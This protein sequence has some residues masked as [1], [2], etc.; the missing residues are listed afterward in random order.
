M[1]LFVLLGCKLLAGMIRLQ[2]C[3]KWSSLLFV[4]EVP[5]NSACDSKNEDGTSTDRNW[6]EEVNNLF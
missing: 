2:L 1:Q 4:V 5:C 6:P 3:G